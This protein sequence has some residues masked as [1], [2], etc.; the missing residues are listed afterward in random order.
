MNSS[1]S[2]SVNDNQQRKRLIPKPLPPARPSKSRRQ[3]RVAGE[4]AQVFETVDLLS[5]NGPVNV[6]HDI[7]IRPNN[8]QLTAVDVQPNMSNIRLPSTQEVIDTVFTDKETDDAIDAFLTSI[9]D[10]DL[11]RDNQQRP[12]SPDIFQVDEN[13]YEL[14]TMTFMDEKIALLQTKLKILA[15]EGQQL[16]DDEF[17]LLGRLNEIK[18]NI[19]I[20]KDKVHK[21]KN[22]LEK[23]KTFRKTL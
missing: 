23:Y 8:P 2:N 20:N 11:I 4:V 5:Q 7:T 19:N 17:T 12:I 14:D 21:I 6:L 13:A 9:E 3:A 1:S 22:N 15:T 10:Q 16:S 18:L